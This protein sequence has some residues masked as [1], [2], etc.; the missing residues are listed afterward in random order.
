MGERIRQHKD[1][2]KQAKD[3]ASRVLREMA[4]DV[5]SKAFIKQMVTGFEAADACEPP[6]SQS[7]RWMNRGYRLQST[8]ATRDGL[9]AA[10]SELTADIYQRFY[11]APSIQAALIVGLIRFL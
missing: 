3:A 4:S 5:W 9:T 8:Q 7:Q 6:A 2:S 11:I 1:L 10:L